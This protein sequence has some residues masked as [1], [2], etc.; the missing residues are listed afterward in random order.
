[1]PPIIDAKAIVSHRARRLVFRNAVPEATRTTILRPGALVATALFLAL[2]ACGGGD[3]SSPAG[4]RGGRGAQGI[5]EAG[6]VVVKASTVPIT[7]DLAGRTSA[8]ET[9]DVRPQVSGV[10]HSR[11]FVEG[12][13][14]RQGQTLYQVDPSTYQAA[15][16][17]ARANLAAAVAT[18]DAAVVKANR[19]APLARMQAVSQQEYTDARAAAQQAAA[20]VKQNQAA[21]QTASINLHYTRVPAP[22]TGR[23]GRSLVTTGALVTANQTNA[24]ATIERIDPMYVDIQ[25]SSAQLLALR[26]Q[27]AVGGAVPARAQVRLTLEDG[28]DYPYAGTLEFAEEV[29]DP[30]TGAITLRAR[31]PNPQGLLLPGM[32]VRARLVQQTIS[33]AIL[34]PQAGVSRDPQGNATVM[35]IGPGNKPVQRTVTADRTLGE[36]WIVTAGLQ[37][38]DRVIVEGLGRIRPGEVVTPVPAG[39]PP[40][41]HGAAQAGAQAGGYGAAANRG[42]SQH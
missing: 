42:G 9:A 37:P 27:I 19:Y 26:R 24:L 17:Q 38:G 6:Y 32:Y 34:V 21:L 14:V 31:F 33:N 10:I 41:Q 15:V 12:S 7:V 5:P 35:V 16:A 13:V 11:N 28:S 40:R 20:S 4:G 30:T 8:F 1:M 36:D 2:A 39:S 22:I 18:R 25:Q 23:I 3:G 29:V